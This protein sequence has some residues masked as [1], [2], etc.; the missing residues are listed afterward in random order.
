MKK[1]HFIVD[2]Q[3]ISGIVYGAS[4]VKTNE[5]PGKKGHSLKEWPFFLS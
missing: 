5:L 4:K 1:Q 2:K 3:D